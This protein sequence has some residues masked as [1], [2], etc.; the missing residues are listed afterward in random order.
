MGSIVSSVTDAV[1]L[2]NTRAQESAANAA[3]SATN[4]SVA[5]SKE[6]IDFA[7]EQYNEWKAVYGDIQTNL[8]KYYNSLNASDYEAK[9]LNTVQQEYSIAK[10]RINTE[11]AQ[12]GISDSGIAAVADINMNQRLAEVKA[13]IRTTANEKVAEDKLKF[14]GVGLGQGSA[15]LGVE[16]AAANNAAGNL[17]NSANS[18]TQ[19]STAYGTAG[20][21][22]TGS[23]IGIGAGLALSDKRLKTNLVKVYTL[24]GITFYNWDWNE[25]ANSLGYNGRGFGVIAQEVQD[26]IPDSV[27][28]TG[29]YLAVDYSKV[30]NYIGDKNGRS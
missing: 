27:Y 16:S 30:L 12:R 6:Q 2:T 15:L 7:K 13:N 19:S 29:Y 11:L 3:T 4:A 26:V 25:L 14:L 20:M 8:G 17:M 10:E 1:G 22:N 5:M 9:G 28:D 24:Q 21:N 23:L 18:Y